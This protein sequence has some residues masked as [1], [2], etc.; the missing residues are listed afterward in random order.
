VKRLAAYLV[1]A[2]GAASA[3]EPPPPAP[4]W[5]VK[6]HLLSDD[7]RV[8]LRRATAGLNT[9]VCK[10]PCDAVVPFH[11]NE[12]FTLGGA[13][14][15]TSDQ[16]VFPPRDG[17]LTLRVIAKPEAPRTTGKA[18][19]VVGAVS[20]AASNIYLIAQCSSQGIVNCSGGSLAASGALYLGGAAAIVTGILFLVRNHTT[21]AIVE[22]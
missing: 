21:E 14:M 19:I 6:V 12:T 11:D 10:T 15:T 18:L 17:N 9:T 13:G 3:A 4:T 5:S 2:A 22:N 16:I 7:A 1:L 20:V 8:E